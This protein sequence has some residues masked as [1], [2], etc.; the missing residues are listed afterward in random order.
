MDPV[1]FQALSH[2]HSPHH[3]L[4]RHWVVLHCSSNCSHHYPCCILHKPALF[5]N[6]ISLTLS[7]CCPL[8]RH[9]VV[10]HC[11]F[12]CSHHYLCHLLHGSSV[13]SSIISLTLTSSPSLK[14]LGSVTLQFQLQSL[15]SMLSITQ[16]SSFSECYLA[17]TSPHCPLS[18]HQVVSH[19]SFDGSC[20]YLC[21]CADP[22]F[23]SNIISLTHQL[24]ALSQGTG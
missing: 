7:P 20:H 13:F 9:Q 2:L 3:P 5:P 17:H 19:C 6:I 4:S 8:S 16:T 24:V 1:F 21:S 22:L 14:A 10:S 11:S 15:L 23:F 12:D 18:R